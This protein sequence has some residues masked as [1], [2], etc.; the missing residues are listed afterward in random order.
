MTNLV[1]IKVIPTEAMDAMHKHL[2]LYSKH[3][4]LIALAAGLGA[5]PGIEQ[6]DATSIW[7]SGADVAL[8][9]RINLPLPPQEKTDE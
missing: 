6:L 2:P 3:Q 4:V 5:W 9:A 1:S 8:P 7:I